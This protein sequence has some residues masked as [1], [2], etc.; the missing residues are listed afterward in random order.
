MTKL[1]ETLLPEA[2][3]DLIRD[4]VI[5]LVSVIVQAEPHPDQPDD[6]TSMQVSL[7]VRDDFRDG[8]P[9]IEAGRTRLGGITGSAADDLSVA[10]QKTLAAAL[11]R[12]LREMKEWREGKANGEPVAAIRDPGLM[13]IFTPEFYRQNEKV[14]IWSFAWTAAMSDDGLMLLDCDEPLLASG[15]DSESRARIRERVSRVNAAITGIVEPL[16]QGR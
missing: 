11:E 5:E 10:T 4:G 9:A 3:E 16:M 6:R 1:Y 14:T 15:L 2:Q 13:K 7:E 8:I 12:R